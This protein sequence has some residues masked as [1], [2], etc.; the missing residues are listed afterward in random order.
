MLKKCIPLIFAFTFIICAPACAENLR[1]GTIV[2][3]EGT[4]SVQQA[5]QSVK[6]KV[7]DPVYLNDV[8]TTDKES[9]LVTLLIDDTQFI[10]A[11]NTSFKVNDYT[12][13]PKQEKG[14]RAEY[15]ILKGAFLY[16][17]G[18]LSKKNEG[19][20]TIKNNY[21][22][23]GIRGTTVWGGHVENKGYGVLVADGVAQ[24]M[25]NK[26][27]IRLEAGQGTFIT[28]ESSY[29]SR[30]KVW[31]APV[32]KAALA[33]ITLKDQD[34]LKTKLQTVKTLNNTLR[35]GEQKTEEMEENT[36]EEIEEEE[37]EESEET[38]EEKTE[39]DQMTPEEV[40]M[41][42]R[43]MQEVVRKN[44]AARSKK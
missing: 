41:E 13:D 14:G 20:I 5:T 16:V 30:A 7:N 25:T 31:G 29:P 23:I 36:T 3:I 42:R 11:E 2:E 43:R 19:H 37:A 12:Y 26:G 8:L 44:R 17:S 34:A 32:M 38:T 24:F 21:G 27:S 4:A 35:T 10:L 28:K 18:L 9:K 40:E 6:L 39:K 1:I 22:T 15:N 33:T